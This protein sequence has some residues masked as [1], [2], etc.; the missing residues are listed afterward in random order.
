MKNIENIEKMGPYGA[1][2]CRGPQGSINIRVALVCLNMALNHKLFIYV[3]VYAFE[4]HAKG[5]GQW[6]SM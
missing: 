4:R 2:T 5:V 1:Y 6:K 3:C